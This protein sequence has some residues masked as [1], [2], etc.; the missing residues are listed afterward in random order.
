MLAIRAATAGD[1]P[2][3]LRFFRELAEFER[4]PGAVLPQPRRR[5][6]QAQAHP[7]WVQTRKRSAYQ[8]AGILPME[9]RAVLLEVHPN[10]SIV[11]MCRGAP[12]AVFACGD[13]EG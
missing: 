1:V 10:W 4:Q 6:C 2:L 3:L 5:A 12:H 8:L 7:K 11:R 9:I 13:F